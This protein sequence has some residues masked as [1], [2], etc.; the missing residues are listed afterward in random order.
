MPIL[1]IVETTNFNISFIII[2]IFFEEE[3]TL[4]FYWALIQLIQLYK[5][6]QSIYIGFDKDFGLINIFENIS[7]ISM[8]LFCIWLIQKIYLDKLQEVFCN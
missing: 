3:T 6:I 5:N 2:I 7:Y 8:V 1:H 4:C